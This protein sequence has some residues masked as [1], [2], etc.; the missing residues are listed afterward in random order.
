MLEDPRPVSRMVT[1]APRYAIIKEKLDRPDAPLDTVY[2][3]LRAAFPE[4]TADTQ[5]GLRLEWPDRWV[6]VRP[7]GTEPV[8]RVIA[9][10]P[11]R[12][13]ALTLVERGRALL[14][15]LA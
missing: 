12:T 7:S 15:S 11:S 13:D 2:Q 5:D 8:V 4:A 9:E 6:H 1:D 14:A 10:A 3:A